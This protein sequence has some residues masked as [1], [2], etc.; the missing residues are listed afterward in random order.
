MSRVVPAGG[1]REV[2]GRTRQQTP[3]S[4]LQRG[5]E[6]GRWGRGL[7]VERVRGRGW[8]SGEP[9]GESQGESLGSRIQLLSVYSAQNIGNFTTMGCRVLTIL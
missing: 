9:V 2:S 3:G 8:Q 1:P 7:W 6:S 4:T 5:R